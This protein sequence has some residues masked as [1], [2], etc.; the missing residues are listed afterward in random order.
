MTVGALRTIL[1]CA[2]S[3]T[4]AL[5]CPA[6]Q[7]PAAVSGFVIDAAQSDVFNS[8]FDPVD[9]AALA[10]FW[11]FSFVLVVILYLF[12]KYIGQIIGMVKSLI[13]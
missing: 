2:A 7:A 8:A 10:S 13:R 5:P 6:G 4:P 12:S 9:P 1:V 11:G 3:D